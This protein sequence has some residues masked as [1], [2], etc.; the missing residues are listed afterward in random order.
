MKRFWNVVAVMAVINLVALGG[1]LL[2]LKAS[3][4]IDP[5]RIQTARGLFAKTLEEE[6]ADKAAKEAEA[7]AEEA[8]AAEAAK[9]AR[10]PTSSSEKIAEQQFRDDQRLQVILR[11]QQE[12]ENLRSSL[13]GQL[14]K[15]EER[16]K[17]LDVDKKAFADERK[18]IAEAD[19]TKQFQLALGTLEGQ[20]AVDAKK[21]LKALLDE[22]QAD[23]VVSYLAKMED[24]K[25]AKIMA[26]FVKDDAAVAADLLERL[27][28]R[29]VAIP[30][31]SS[32]ANAPAPSS[33]QVSANDAGFA[34][35][36]GR[37]ESSVADSRAGAE[38]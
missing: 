12:L 16:E 26:E 33:S 2:W 35:T 34:G 3:H 1:L 9:L 13:M 25:R 32:A 4:R 15:L 20:K 24:G 14:S 17:K 30:G 36:N 21:V 22:K 27:R 29:G 7:K 6:A 18:R 11:Q 31:R 28:T 23:Q 19:G 10:P 5:T 37:N 38:R 8:R